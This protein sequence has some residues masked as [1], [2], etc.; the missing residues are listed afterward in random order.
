MV[1]KCV[2]K[3]DIL[4]LV[5]CLQKEEVIAFPTETVYG[6]G[7]VYDSPLAMERLIQAKH[8]PENKPFTLMVAHKEDIGR[9]A[10][11]RQRDLKLIEGLMPGEV[12][13]IFNRREDVDSRITNGYPTIGVRMPN[14]PFVLEMIA[15]CGKPLLVPS[16]NI[17]GE[18]ACLTSDEV[19]A[20]MKD[21][22]SLIVE[23][24]CGSGV[25]S[26]IIDLTK[27]DISIIRQGRMTMSQIEEVLE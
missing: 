25:A 9:F 2:T 19:F 15:T 7:I 6:L 13:F 12:T 14:D 17:S 16:A 3:Q 21:S 8:R 22:V 10:K 20:C 26:T 24:K 27:E 4:A 18:P 11:L 23:G 5:E 1:A